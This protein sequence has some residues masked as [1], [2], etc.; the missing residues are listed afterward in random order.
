MKKL[1]SF[2]FVF[3]GMFFSTKINAQDIRIGFPRIEIGERPD[4]NSVSLQSMN[5]QVEIFGNLAKTTTT[6]VFTNSSSRNLEGNLVFPLPE[7]TTVS[8]YAIDINGKLRNAVPVTKVRAVE[9]FESIQKQN[10]DPGIIEKVEGNNFRTRISPIPAKGSRT[11]QLSY[12]QELKLDKSSYQYHLPL[13]SSKKIAKFNLTTKVYNAAGKPQLI[14]TPDGS[15]NFSE[16][17]NIY[18]A[19]LSKTDFTPKKSLIIN[20][21]KSP[22]NVESFVQKNVDGSV[23]FYANLLVDAKSQP[24]VW[25]KNIGII[26]DNSLSGLKRNHQ[27]E[28]EFLDKIISQQ[29]NLNIEVSLLNFSLEKSR[30][31]QIKN[32]DWSELKKYL[33]NVTY[34]GGTNYAKILPAS[35][36][37]D[38]YLLFSDGIS[39]FGSNIFNIDKPFYT[40]ASSPTSNYGVLKMIAQ[41]VGGKFIN[42]NENSVENAFKQINE[43]SVQFLGIIN[44]TAGEVYPISTN[45]VNNGIS[46]AGISQ[47]PNAKLMMMFG[48]NGKVEFNK[49]LDLSKATQ[50]LE[51]SKIWAQSK[52]N[53]LELNLEQYKTEIEEIGKQFSIVTSNTSLIVLENVSD[54]VKYKIN[55]PAEL[56]SEFNK[57]SKQGFEQNETR[58]A[59]LLKNAIAKAKELKEWW[60]KDFKYIKPKYPKPV[61][62]STTYLEETV[63]VNMVMPEPRTTAVMEMESSAEQAMVVT[64]NGVRRESRSLGYASANFVADKKM[65]DESSASVPEIKIVNVKSDKEY[66]KLIEASK[67]PY[68]TYLDLRKDYAETPAYYFDVATFFFQKKEKETGLKILSSIADLGL[69]D[70]ELYKMLAYKLKEIEEYQTELFITKKVLDWRPFDAQSYRDYALALQDNEQYQSALE[71][72]YKVL[73]NDY[74]VEI[75]NRDR[76][77]TEIIVPEVNNLISLHRKELNL[78]KIN[79]DIIVDIPVD[80]RVVMNWNKDMTDIDLWVT[81]PNGEK[82]FYGHRTTAIG[83]RMS[84]DVTQGFGPEQFMLKKAIKGKYKI[85]TNFFGERQMSISGPTTISAEIYLMYSSGKQVKKMITFQNNKPNSG[86]EGILVG[87]FEF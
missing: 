38:E 48:R 70:A 14:E 82:C 10:I 58:K 19:N 8:G 74:S 29:K 77:I 15:F 35:L 32:G 36:K 4:E 59:D 86:G 76:D 71:Y 54:Y 39:S 44:N 9:V 20:L 72:L 6:L 84:E 51:I 67:N 25:S 23:Y 31:F 40:I 33:E 60:K 78:S 11:I 17:S 21:P 45:D 41:K 16:N 62:D 87:E 81:D 57:L 66:M 12:Y 61:G 64:A 24:K 65:K 28:L 22:N 13:D 34:D 7:N 73:T 26:W 3:V 75:A 53:Y 42:L 47:Y 52:V 43:S 55:P 5:V 49:E 68:Q 79:K 63:Q 27:K 18:E 30:F 37:A 85:E 83:G 56:Q 80:I 2:F 69:E 1:F 46:I 50:N